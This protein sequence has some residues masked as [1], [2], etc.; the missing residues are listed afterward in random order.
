M[1]KKLDVNGQRIY[2]VW[3]FNRW[4]GLRLSVVGAGFTIFVGAFIIGLRQIDASL[5][6]FV[7]SFALTYNGNVIWSLRRYA[8]TELNMN[9]KLAGR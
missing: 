5:A 2:Y 3:L 8:S 1:F 7:L 9:S 6:G 4:V